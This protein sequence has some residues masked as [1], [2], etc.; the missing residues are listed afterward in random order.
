MPDLLSE[1]ECLKSK[2]NYWAR[3]R[4]PTVTEEFIHDSLRMKHNP[5]GGVF[6]LY[7]VC[8][9]SSEALAATALAVCGNIQQLI[10]FKSIFTHRSCFIHRCQAGQEG[11]GALTTSSCT[12]TVQLCS[13]IFAKL[14]V[15]K[16][17][18]GN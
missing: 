9:S 15:I 16:Q 1:S 12:V 10:C 5:T 2:N 7:S 11:A 8:S 17:T 18:V 6:P 3:S 14:I 4:Q 13:P